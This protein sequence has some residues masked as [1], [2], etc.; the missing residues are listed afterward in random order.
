MNE[1]ASL[2]G[3]FYIFWNLHPP[4]GKPLLVALMTGTFA[5]ESEQVQI[6]RDST[7]AV[8]PNPVLTN[9]VL[10][11]LPDTQLNSDDLVRDAHSVL[12]RIFGPATPLPIRSYCTRWNSDPYACGSYSYVKVGSSGKEYDGKKTEVALYGF[13]MSKKPCAHQETLW[14]VPL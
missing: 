9:M 1:T 7:K 11:L 10:L 12:S 6:E 3:K 5:V 13:D 8:L 14:C 2:R 4:T